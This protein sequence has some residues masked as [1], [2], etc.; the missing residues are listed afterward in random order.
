MLINAHNDEV[1]FKLPDVL[2]DRVWHEELSTSWD[3]PFQA[4]RDQFRVGELVAVVG[5]SIR[6]L[7]RREH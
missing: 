3:N 1:R 4:Q 7:R 6:V 5:H 2:N